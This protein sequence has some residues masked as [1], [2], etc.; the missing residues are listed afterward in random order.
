MELFKFYIKI[1]PISNCSHCESS[2]VSSVLNA[3][4]GGWGLFFILNVR[5]VFKKRCKL[6]PVVKSW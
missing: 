2:S 1:V 6:I 4:Y 3:F 5:S